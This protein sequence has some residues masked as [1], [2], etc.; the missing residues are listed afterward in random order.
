MLWALGEDNK[1]GNCRG[2]RMLVTT[3]FPLLSLDPQW[4]SPDLRQVETKISRV[5]D[6]AGWR[7]W[8]WVLL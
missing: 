4:R 5:S 1:E 7:V 8:L 3:S 6:K 2:G